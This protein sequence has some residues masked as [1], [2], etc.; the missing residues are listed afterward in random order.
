MSMDKSAFKQS[1]TSSLTD[2]VDA[3]ILHAVWVA[4]GVPTMPE[5]LFVPS[6]REL[7]MPGTGWK[8]VLTRSPLRE[9]HREQS[10]LRGSKYR[11]GADLRKERETV[12]MR[13]G[14]G[15]AQRP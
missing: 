5:V 10:V 12:R 3:T 4:F 1:I 9:R 11:R 13:F 8:E 6:P 15:A 2:D 14:P 7:A